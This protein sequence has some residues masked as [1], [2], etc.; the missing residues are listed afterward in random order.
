MD[1]IE[2]NEQDLAKQKIV[3]KTHKGEEVVGE[4]DDLGSLVKVRAYFTVHKTLFL[5]K[6]KKKRQTRGT[7]DSIKRYNKI[8]IKLK[9]AVAI[10]ENI[11]SC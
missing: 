11:F 7:Q 8:K 6:K 4:S 2:S 9:N 3:K 5:I 1:L 10:I